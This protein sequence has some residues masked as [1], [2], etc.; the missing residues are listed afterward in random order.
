MIIAI[1]GTPGTGKST[2]AS[3][4][5]DFYPVLHLNEIVKSEGF[6]SGIDEQ[7][8][9]LEVEMEALEV[10]L[11][12]LIASSHD[13]IIEG[14]IAHLLQIDYDMVIVLRCMPSILYDRLRA[15]GFNE[16]KIRENIEA[17]ALDLILVEALEGGFKAVYE[18]NTTEQDANSVAACIKE[19]IEGNVEAYRVGGVDWSYELQQIADGSF[20]RDRCL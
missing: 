9:S 4:M 14:H 6:Y 5:S 20:W 16:D 7:R 1:T 13:L 10:Y 19:I 17:E 3:I 12:N 8:G 15:K 2:V 18:V 11:Q